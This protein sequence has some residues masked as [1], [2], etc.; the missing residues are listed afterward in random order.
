MFVYAIVCQGERYSQV[1]VAAHQRA[2]HVDFCN[3]GMQY[4]DGWVS[5]LTEVGRAIVSFQVERV[6]VSEIVSRFG[7][8]KSTGAYVIHEQSAD[9][10]VN[11]CW[12]GLERRLPSDEPRLV[13]IVREAA[14]RPELRQL[15]P[16]TAHDQ[17][18]F[19]RT[20]GYPYS[21]D[22]P[23]AEP[24]EGGLFRVM[25]ADQKTVLG[26]GDVVRAADILV[27]NLPQ[28]CGPAIH[29]TA[30]NLKT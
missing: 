27:A 17:L 4:G 30:E 8:F 3:R 11:Q 28:N 25:S 16:F 6:S 20:T 21:Y 26:E 19:S 14:K 22:C 23:L 1:F 29:G 2:F 18:C 9:H 7:W 24:I 12:E 15:R 13:P 5:D 10:F